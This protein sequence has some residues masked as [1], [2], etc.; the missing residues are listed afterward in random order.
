MTSSQRAINICLGVLAA[1]L[2]MLAIAGCD[3]GGSG[4]GETSRDTAGHSSSDVDSL[5]ETR[6]GD[7]LTS[8]TAPEG[9]SMCTIARDVS[10]ALDTLQRWART[11][12]RDDDSCTLAVLDS[13]AARFVGTGDDR[14]LI[15]LDSLQSHS[16]GAVAEHIQRLCE[17][18]LAERPDD[19]LSYLDTSTFDIAPMAWHLISSWTS[20][21]ESAADSNAARRSIRQRVRADMRSA[22]LSPSS[23]AYLD[24]LFRRARLVE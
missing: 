18:M 22:V 15:T 14:Y 6:A 24:S 1:L 8:D 5:G 7:A 10:L 11:L 9:L 16:D 20:E 13:L 19:F 17:R 21:L 4:A 3:D 12:V 23:R 2:A